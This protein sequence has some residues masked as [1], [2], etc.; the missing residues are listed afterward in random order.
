VFLS[1][2][3]IYNYRSIE[4]LELNFSRGKNVIVGKNNAGKSNVIRAID[5]A[6][7]EK[8][9]A[10]EK[11]E[12]ITQNDF[13][14][15]DLSKR[16]LIFCELSRCEGEQLDYNLFADKCISFQRVREFDI[17]TLRI[18]SDERT[19]DTAEADHFL[20]FM[21]DVFETATDSA[22]SQ[23][24]FGTWI[25]PKKYKSEPKLVVHEFASSLRRPPMRTVK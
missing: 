8:A 7:G 15:G 21:S 14:N 19:A 2:V 12:N 22:F 6:L 25:N 1:R 9:P 13:H 23:R 17:P 4:Q 3:R 11:T 16:I 18:R 24:D 10:Y 5:L 20:R